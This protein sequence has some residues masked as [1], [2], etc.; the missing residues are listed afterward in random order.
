V[1]AR[2]E[3]LVT[4][5]S[6]SP[7]DPP[8]SRPDF[9]KARILNLEEVLKKRRANSQA[10]T[11]A[12]SENRA[13]MKPRSKHPF[14]WRVPRVWLRILRDAEASS[15]LPL[16]L[17]IYNQMIVRKRPAVSITAKVWEVA[18]AHT[19]QERRTM[20]AALKRVPDLV[21][22]DYRDRLGSKYRASQGPLWDAEYP[23]PDN[24]SEDDSNEMWRVRSRDPA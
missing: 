6:R 2:E 8:S 12:K 5:N 18:E 22:L 7:S 3:V 21:R 9:G 1:C 23:Y 17:A 4:G 16:L 10:Q 19:R 24:D 11:K 14:I 15:A 20:L 13:F